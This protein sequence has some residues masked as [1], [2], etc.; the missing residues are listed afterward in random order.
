VAGRE[1]GGFQQTAVGTSLGDVLRVSTEAITRRMASWPDR[2]MVT[3]SPYG[4]GEEHH[5]TGGKA[6]GAALVAADRVARLVAFRT[7]GEG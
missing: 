2:E 3:S 4:L 6:A 1:A 7:V 5:V